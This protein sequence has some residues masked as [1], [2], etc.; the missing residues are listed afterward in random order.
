MGVLM[1]RA[2]PPTAVCTHNDILAMGALHAIHTAGLQVPGDI[3]VVGYD[4][5]ASAAYF[6]PPLTTI[7]SPRAEIGTRAGR[8]IL[9]LVQNPEAIPL[10]MITLPVA[11]IVRLSTA[12]PPLARE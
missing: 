9:A 11:L 4:D 6:S 1:G 10:Q 5:I 8:M 7:R 2:D 3:S 12:P